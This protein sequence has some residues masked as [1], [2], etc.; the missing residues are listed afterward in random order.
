MMNKKL[1]F[2][3][4]LSLG[5]FA[6]NA[7]AKPKA[8]SNFNIDF[9]GDFDFQTKMI[10]AQDTQPV[11]ENWE[12][13]NAMWLLNANIDSK[14]EL[15]Q[16]KVDANLFIRYAGSTLYKEENLPNTAVLFG[17][18][19]Y[20]LVARDIFKL[21]HTESN[22]DSSTIALLN[23]FTYEIGDSETRFVIGRQRIEYGEGRTFNPLNPF[24]LPLTWST[25]KNVFVGNDGLSFHLNKAVD[26]TVRLYLLGDKQ[27][28]DYDDK[29]TRTI[30]VHGR[31]RFSEKLV[32]SY[33]LGEDQERY[34]YGGEVN[35]RWGNHQFYV[36]AI[37]QSKLIQ[38]KLNSE[39]MTHYVVGF[40]RN[41]WNKWRFYIEF[42]KRDS[43]EVNGFTP[44][45]MYINMRNFISFMNEVKISRK[46][47]MNINLLQNPKSEMVYLHYEAFY[48]LGKY[49]KLQGF[50]GRVI[51]EPENDPDYI[52]QQTIPHQLG[53]GYSAAF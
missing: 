10:E 25:Q 27:F 42:G 52:Y 2:F 43:D 31:K 36:Q 28:T 46:L 30:W 14:I 35:F 47:N 7:L 8:K 40:N 17:V 49:S 33:V 3:L 4:T 45:L 19:P 22:E 53:L 39:P 6:I 34:N 21:E 1:S 24:M 12:G 32:L 51:T 13:Q 18:Y 44:D 37:K 48:K 15:F 26:N 5:L 29:I 11:S 20:N 38:D 16:N 41:M 50:I 23:K 9:N